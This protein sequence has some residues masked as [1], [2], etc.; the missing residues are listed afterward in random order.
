MDNK[1]INS[2]VYKIY[3]KDENVK[4]IYVGSTINFKKRCKD[5]KSRC[6]NINSEKYN[7]KLYKFIRDNGN[8]DNFIIEIIKEYPCEN[9]NQLET[10]EDKYIVELNPTLNSFRASRNQKQY[11]EDNKEKLAEKDKQYY[12]KNSEKIKEK[13]KQYYENNKERIAERKKIKTI[14][15]CGSYYR[16]SDKTKH[17]RS[18]KHKAY[19]FL[20]SIETK[21]S[22]MIPA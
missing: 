9:K 12:E 10:E 6:N 4:D 22:K 7:Y 18:Q 1:Y 14:C 16:L 3:C 2:V 15:P 19:E 11:Y 21:Y 5:H 20:N 8:F 13:S 17:V